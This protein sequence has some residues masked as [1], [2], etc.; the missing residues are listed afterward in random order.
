MENQPVPMNAPNPSTSES[1]DVPQTSVGVSDTPFWKRLIRC[2][3]FYLVSA[4]LLIYGIYRASVDPHFLGSET[5][6]VIFNFSSLEIYG[7]MLTVAAVFLSCRR[8][9]YDAVLLIFIENVLV[10]VPFILISHAVFLDSNL[11]FAMSFVAG[12][13]VL[14]KFTAFKSLFRN[15]NL[16]RELLFLGAIIL[17]ANIAIPLVFRKGLD[18]DN[19]LWTVR[20]QYC[21][22]ILLPL[23]AAS[24]HILHPLR[25]VDASLDEHRKPWIPLATFLLWI[26]GSAAHLYSVGYVDDQRFELAKFSVLSWSIAW[27]LCAKITLVMTRF[28]RH[29]PEIMLGLPTA[30]T[31]LALNRPEIAITL[32][33]LNAAVFGVLCFRWAAPRLPAML[34]GISLLL[35]TVMVPDHWITPVFSHYSKGALIFVLVNAALIVVAVRMRTAKWGWVGAICV[36]ALVAVPRGTTFR[37]LNTTQFSSPAAFC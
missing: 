36:A 30:T 1:A 3:P 32:N 37:L 35:A 11:A 19:E 8:I 10:L 13:L 12:G 25:T 14:A 20:S 34:G 15:L 5:R 29:A 17:A 28:T 22:F 18:A 2:N 26:S 31:L 23:L 7:L 27:L 24:G 33:L 6:Q 21:W 4:V 16:P 9:F